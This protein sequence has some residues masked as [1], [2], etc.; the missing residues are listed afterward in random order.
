LLKSDTQQQA[1]IDGE[2]TTLRVSGTVTIRGV[3]VHGAECLLI[4]TDRHPH[5]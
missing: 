3:A 5:Q 2:D 4:Y 1:N